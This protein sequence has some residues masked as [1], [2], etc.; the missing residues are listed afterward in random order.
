VTAPKTILD[1]AQAERRAFRV[2]LEGLTPEQWQVQSLCAGWT[3]RDVAAHVV[4]YDG[5]TRRE[6]AGRFTR[7]L[8][9]PWRINAAGADTDCMRTTTEL[10][11]LFH[12][13]ERPRGLATGL[14]GVIGLFDGLVHQQDVRRPLGLPRTISADHL[15]VALRAALFAP[16]VCGIIRAVGLRLVATD[17]DWSFG[18]GPEVSGP[19]EAILMAIAGRKGVVNELGGPGQHTLAC[20]IG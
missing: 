19:A 20:R 15:R 14:G 6:I 10:V 13:Y 18:R 17:L 5:L 1:M 7:G 12:Q 11:S 9:L 3:V 8:F 2:L 4:S 16:V